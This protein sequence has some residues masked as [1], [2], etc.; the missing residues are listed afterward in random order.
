MTHGSRA[1][2]MSRSSCWVDAGS[3]DDPPSVD[4]R[5]LL[6]HRDRGRHRRNLHGDRQLHVLSQI[7]GDILPVDGRE[8][9]VREENRVG[10]GRKVQD[11]KLA[12]C[13]RRDR[14]RRSGTLDRN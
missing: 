9:L 8:A 13:V 14:L 4:Q 12:A 5:R 1:V 3:G 11:V 10:S 6:R 7:D 2:G